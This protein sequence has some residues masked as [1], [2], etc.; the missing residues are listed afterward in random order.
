MTQRVSLLEESN[1]KSDYQLP[2]GQLWWLCRYSDHGHV[3]EMVFSHEK[4][5]TWFG[6]RAIA[7]VELMNLGLQ[8]TAYVVTL[9]ER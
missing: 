9:Y 2:S 7:Q 4:A 6:A 1:S 5:K 8:N 3:S